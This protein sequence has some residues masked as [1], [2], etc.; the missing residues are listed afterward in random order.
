MANDCRP[1]SPTSFMNTSDEQTRQAL[2]NWGVMPSGVTRIQ[3]GGVQREHDRENTPSFQPI[4]PAIERIEAEDD[5][6]MTKPRKRCEMHEPS[7]S[8]SVGRRLGLT[9]Q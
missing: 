7:G 5:N 2:W 8:A 3:A 9:E 1:S 6:D 4:A